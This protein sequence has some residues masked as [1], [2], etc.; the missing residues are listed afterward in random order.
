MGLFKKNKPVT[1]YDR[2]KLKPAI[3]ASICTGEQTA[4]FVEIKTG[5]FKDDM[6]IRGANDLYIFKEKYGITGEIEKIY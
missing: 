3:K 4:G 1:G 2:E 5:H 6:L